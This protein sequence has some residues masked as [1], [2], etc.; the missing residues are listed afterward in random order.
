MCCFSSTVK[1][2]T[3]PFPVPHSLPPIPSFMGSLSMWVCAH[4][5][6]CDKVVYQCCCFCACSS[7]KVQWLSR[8]LVGGR[9]SN[10]R[11]QFIHIPDYSLFCMHTH[12]HTTH[13]D[14]CARA[15]THTHTHTHTV[16]HAHTHTHTSVVLYRSDHT[17]H[18]CP[19]NEEYICMYSM[20]SSLDTRPNFSLEPSGQ[21]G[22]ES[23]T[24]KRIVLGIYTQHLT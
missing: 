3:I 24:L 11:G 16:T 20:E 2:V 6:F 7:G 13:G 17:I 10:A 22:M 19:C 12:M 14:T 23:L 4:A 21:T 8:G 18:V 9:D 1:S 15:H 5:V